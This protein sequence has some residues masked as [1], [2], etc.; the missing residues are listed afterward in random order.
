VLLPAPVGPLMANRP[1]EAKGSDFKIDAEFFGQRGQVLAAD[2]QDSHGSIN[3]AK[4]LS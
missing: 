1:V 3:S 2:F 4:A